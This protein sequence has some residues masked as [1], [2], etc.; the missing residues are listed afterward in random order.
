MSDGAGRGDA[1]ADA[2]RR[3]WLRLAYIVA[4]LLVALAAATGAIG[5]WLL[6]AAV[7]GVL[8]AIPRWQ[9]LSGVFGTRTAR[10]GGSA[11]LMSVAFIGL[12]YLVPR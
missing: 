5:G 8:Y 4:G 7:L 3:P 10:Q 1:T 9:D 2:E 6:S 11:T 12:L